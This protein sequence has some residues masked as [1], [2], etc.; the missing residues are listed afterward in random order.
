[1]AESF[2]T[3]GGEYTPM[4]ISGA[5]EFARLGYGCA[6]PA[7][8]AMETAT[9]RDPIPAKAGRTARSPLDCILDG[10]CE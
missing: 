4:G 1:M 9:I 7:G 3:S 8:L 10:G 2:T 6:M 5:K